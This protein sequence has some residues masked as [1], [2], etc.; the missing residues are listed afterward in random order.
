MRQIVAT[1]VV[2]AI[3]AP[4][5]GGDTVLYSNNVMAPVIGTGGTRFRDGPFSDAISSQGLYFNSQAFGQTFRILSDG[6]QV[7]RIRVWGSSE[8][9]STNPQSIT[10]LDPNITALQVTVYR[11][12]ANESEFPR[13]TTVPITIPVAQVVQERTDSYV[14]GILTPVF[15]LDFNLNLQ[16]GAGDYLLSLGGVLADGDNAPSFIW[17]NG[18]RDGRS[19]QV[20][21]SS[22]YTIGEI[23]SQWEDWLPVNNAPTSGSM[24]L[25]GIPAPGVITALLVAGAR[26]NRRRRG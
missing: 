1:L 16:L 23:A 6:T 25:Y 13:V 3:G 7:N 11:Y 10:R 22:R 8:T 24:V 21:D 18:E 5:L 15:Q 20:G 12:T 4:A 14:P 2:L 19:Q 26:G 9:T 17:I